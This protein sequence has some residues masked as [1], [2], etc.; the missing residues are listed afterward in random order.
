MKEKNKSR[1]PSETFGDTQK[2]IFIENL[3]KNL[4]RQDAKCLSDYNRFKKLASSYLSDGLSESEC[5]ELLMIDGLSREASESYTS[6]VMA[7][8]QTNKSDEYSFRF[9]DVYGKVWS[10][11]DIG[12]VIKASSVNDARAKAEEFLNDEGSYLESEQIIS[13]DP[14]E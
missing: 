4:K 2:A 1:G 8:N 3:R 6:L 10:S 5:I 12:K 7:N 13:I 9:E 14:I 11:Y